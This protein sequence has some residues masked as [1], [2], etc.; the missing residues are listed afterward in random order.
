[1][2]SQNAL[3]VL[4]GITG[5]LSVPTSV[6]GG[7]VWVYYNKLIHV[8]NANMVLLLD[9]YTAERRTSYSADLQDV[10]NT[11][12]MAKK[13]FIVGSVLL[14]LSIASGVGASLLSQ[15]HAS[16]DHDPLDLSKC[17]VTPPVVRNEAVECYLP[18]TNGEKLQYIKYTNT[19][20]LNYGT[21]GNNIVSAINKLNDLY[22][23]EP[24]NSSVICANPIFPYLCNSSSANSN[25]CDVIFLQYRELYDKLNNS[26]FYGFNEMSNVL[27][28]SS[29]SGTNKEILFGSIANELQPYNQQGVDNDDQYTVM[30]LIIGQLLEHT[31]CWH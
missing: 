15:S 22:V 30:S 6:G 28:T 13:T 1:M 8:M 26:T 5:S 9:T 19:S 3:W 23:Q 17:N 4:C 21:L 10:L 25:V 24:V 7:V 11:Q 2:N 14:L 27:V 20:Y 12:T 16:P 29:S 31:V 18:L